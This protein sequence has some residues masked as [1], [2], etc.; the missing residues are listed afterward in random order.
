MTD[1]E[2][3]TLNA[4]LAAARNSAHAHAH[5]LKVKEQQQEL[6]AKDKRIYMEEVTTAVHL[7]PSAG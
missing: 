5:A 6:A 1:V 7:L 4:K 2:R 3:Q